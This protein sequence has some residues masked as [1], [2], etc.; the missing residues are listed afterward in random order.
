[1]P[2]WKQRLMSSAAARRDPATAARL[3]AEHEARR[4]MADGGVHGQ[5]S[6]TR[7]PGAEGSPS[8]TD[9]GAE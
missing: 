8:T 3:I 5:P 9:D 4:G 1:M 7:P 6:P 2:D